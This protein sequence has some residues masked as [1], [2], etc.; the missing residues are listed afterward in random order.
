MHMDDQSAS[1]ENDVDLTNAHLSNL[2]DVELPD[3]LTVCQCSVSPSERHVRLF[4]REG[5]VH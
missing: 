3:S 5:A 4:P 1:Q 2:D